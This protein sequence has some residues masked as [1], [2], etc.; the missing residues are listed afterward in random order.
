[1]VHLLKLEFNA[2]LFLGLRKLTEPRSFLKTARNKSYKHEIHTGF[3]Q[4]RKTRTF[5]KTAENKS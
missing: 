1:M 5:L 4:I 3:A 2:N